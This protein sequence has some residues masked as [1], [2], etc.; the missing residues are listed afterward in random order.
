MEPQAEHL[1]VQRHK[2]KTL[3]VFTLGERISILSEAKFM[4]TNTYGD[5][6]KRLILHFIIST[7]VFSYF[8]APPI[9]KVIGIPSA[10]QSKKEA[11]SLCVL[12]IL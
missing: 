9:L 12:G 11:L 2:G 7:K 10:Y 8:R 1:F 3:T 5:S 4:K 6:S